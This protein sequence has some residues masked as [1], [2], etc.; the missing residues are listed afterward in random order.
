MTNQFEPAEFLKITNG[1]ELLL[2]P[3]NILRYGLEA[4]SNSVQ[5]FTHGMVTGTHKFVSK[6]SDDVN[7]KDVRFTC[8]MNIIDGWTSDVHRQNKG[9]DKRPKW[10]EKPGIFRGDCEYYC[11]K[12]DDMRRHFLKQHPGISQDFIT[13]CPAC[14]YS[15]RSLSSVR[16]HMDTCQSIYNFAASG[17]DTKLLCPKYLLNIGHWSSEKVSGSTQFQKPV[18][19]DQRELL[20]KLREVT[21][22]SIVKDVNAT[23][24]AIDETLSI[25]SVVI[26][27]DLMDNL[28]QSDED[29]SGLTDYGPPQENTTHTSVNV[30][31]FDVNQHEHVLRMFSDKKYR[32]GGSHEFKN[33]ALYALCKAVIEKQTLLEIENRLNVIRKKYEGYSLDCKFL[34]EVQ[35][36]IHQKLGGHIVKGEGADSFKALENFFPV[37]SLDA[38]NV[39][40]VHRL[41]SEY[42]STHKPLPF[43]HNQIIDLTCDDLEEKLR[44]LEL[45]KEVFEVNEKLQKQLAVVCLGEKEYEEFKKHSILEKKKVSDKLSHATKS[46]RDLELQNNELKEE[47]RLAAS[48]SLDMKK[49]EANVK[50]D[51]LTQ[52]DMFA[53]IPPV[54]WGNFTANGKT[55]GIHNASQ[56]KEE[57]KKR[58]FGFADEFSS[59]DRSR[60]V[61]KLTSARHLVPKPGNKKCGIECED[62]AEQNYHLVSANG[63]LVVEN[64]NLNALTN[65][66]ILGS[67]VYKRLYL[68]A[69]AFCE[70]AADYLYQKDFKSKR[71]LQKFLYIILPR[72]VAAFKRCATGTD[73]VKQL[74]MDIE[75]EAWRR[76]TFIPKSQMFGYLFCEEMILRKTQTLDGQ[77]NNLSSAESLNL[78]TEC[79]GGAAGHPPKTCKML[80]SDWTEEFLGLRES[81]NHSIIQKK[82]SID[83]DSLEYEV[84]ASG[85]DLDRVN[86][87]V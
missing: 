47:K 70:Y 54:K 28:M 84:G 32:E 51:K 27:E 50:K 86:T 73:E 76:L 31:I 17:C 9:L 68:C 42:E 25:Q 66:L 59:G 46:I 67:A 53:D 4:Y 36:S 55:Y 6:K 74:M 38:A 2:R 11:K 15:D 40:E 49:L 12:P 21:G 61:T 33:E 45:E 10:M 81:Y 41:L 35:S 83:L 23:S 20:R 44:S 64:D 85:I 16:V 56:E 8:Q 58:K 5:S 18:V 79:K 78:C 82:A 52:I 22:S 7:G 62:I 87:Y 30:D 43:V 3:T 29:S 65:R 57:K 77:V 69:Q 80:T 48:V 71:R 24:V 63:R 75:A 34:W 13:K 60:K 72:F 26:D 14:H 1:S 37:G 19:G 39:K